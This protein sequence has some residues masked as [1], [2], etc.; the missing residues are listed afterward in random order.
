[1]ITQ[2]RGAVFE[3]LKREEETLSMY[4]RFTKEAKDKALQD[5]FI[6][7]SNDVKTD[8]HMMKN[9]NLHSIVKFGLSIKFQTRTC[10]IDEK[11]IATIHDKAGAKEILKLAIDEINAD[12]EY[13][14]HIADHALFPEVKRLFRIIADKELDHKC[15]LKALQDLIE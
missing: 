7:L 2:L 13:Y 9:L 4:E 5:F 15:K 3:A 1:M 8:I 10:S 12:I 11:N 14:E 6:A